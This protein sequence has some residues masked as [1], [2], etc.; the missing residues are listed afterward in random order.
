MLRRRNLL[1]A[2]GGGLITSRIPVFAQQTVHRIGLILPSSEGGGQQFLDALRRG[3]CDRGFVEGR[4]LAI[5][6]RWGDD[7]QA[8]LGRRHRQRPLPLKDALGLEV[9]F[10]GDAPCPVA[11]VTVPAHSG[12][13]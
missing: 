8:R 11:R 13:L 7:L 4:N 9:Q 6:A 1:R 12:S 10:S 5:D 3:S 2:A